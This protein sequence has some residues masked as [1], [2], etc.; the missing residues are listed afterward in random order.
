MSLPLQITSQ[1]IYLLAA[2]VM[3]LGM[4]Q[5]W[6]RYNQ[7]KGVAEDWLREHHYRVMNLSLPWFRG[8]TFPPSL[9]RNSNRAFV[10]EAIIDDEELGGTGAVWLRV[11][12][13]WLGTS[14]SD[15]EVVWKR[16]PHGGMDEYRP[17]A[18]RLADEQLGL[19]RRIAAGETRF[20]AP[21]RWEKDG[22]KYDEMVEHLLAL[23]RRG[24]I[25]CK[26]PAS[27]EKGVSQWSDVADV[28]LTAVGRDFLESRPQPP[29]QR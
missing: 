12:T 23:S 16:M 27:G 10:F 13:T 5:Y 3:V 20:Y 1:P 18:E 28:A 8:M 2:A 9:L 24:M 19:M 6:W 4:A 22:A 21:R 17:L 11:W 25:T 14:D 7:A 26:E 15:V 29:D